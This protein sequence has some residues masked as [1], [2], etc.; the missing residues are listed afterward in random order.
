MTFTSMVAT[1]TLLIT[2]H[3][4]AADAGPLVSAARQRIETTDARGVG[5][6]V[7]VGPNGNRISHAIT[8][9]A[10]WFPGVLRV[11][12]EIVPAKSPAENAQPSA[13]QGPPKDTRVTI[14]FEMRPDGG[15]T[16]RIFHP[17][18]SAPTT[19]PF[20]RWSE[21]IAGSD[22]NY[23]DFL[24]QELF[25]K[26]QTLLRTDKLGTHVCDVL[27]STPGPSNHSHYAEV[28]TWIDQANGY[29][30]FTEKTLNSPAT[31]KDFTSLGVTQSGGVWTAR[32]V[33]IKV[34]GRPGSTLLL[35]E[36]GST[37]AHLTLQ[38]F[39]PEQISRFEDHP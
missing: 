2:S 1:A 27:K 16:I 29:P 10:H 14:L 13:Q 6:L 20:D 8:L 12:L 36:R 21:G 26:G 32:Q 17:G 25:W 24:Q 4:Y 3:A 38:D 19:L 23:E 7:Q 22:F 15:N 39:S 18:E 5:R 31:I 34:H 9:K 28:Q 30:I 33:E 37:K 35:F 11:L